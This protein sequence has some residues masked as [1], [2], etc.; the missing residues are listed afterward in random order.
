MFKKRTRQMS[1]PF[2]IDDVLVELDDLER[3]HI[4]SGY[5][6]LWL[7]SHARWAGFNCCV[8]AMLIGILL[9][10]ALCYLFGS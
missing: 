3:P 2:K 4:L 5:E 10:W 9:V 1:N 8:F 7:Q 6:V